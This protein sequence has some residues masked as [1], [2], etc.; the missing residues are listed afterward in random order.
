MN[1]SPVSSAGIGSAGE[2]TLASL[3]TRFFGKDEID[4]C[5]AI[6]G[7]GDFL[8]TIRRGGRVFRFMIEAKNVVAVPTIGVEK[9]VRD[10]GRPGI[11]GA[12]FVVLT[13][14][15]IPTKGEVAFEIVGSI[16]VLYINNVAAN[17]EALRLGVEALVFAALVRPASVSPGDDDD[18]IVD[19]SGIRVAVNTAFDVLTHHA[20]S[21]RALRDSAKSVLAALTAVEGETTA[22]VSAINTLWASRPDLRRAEPPPPI[23]V[24]MA[25]GD[26]IELAVVA[27]RQY[28]IEHGRY[29]SI[30]EASESCGVTSTILSKTHGIKNIILRARAL[31]L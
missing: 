16:P 1:P 20:T 5:S 27:V 22:A 19:D 7:H 15:N 13:P 24:V 28:F 10:C 6:S 2:T 11:D 9:F 23:A 31:I 26:P 25:A 8:L 3:L 29:P 14:A 4:K 21:F 12:L 30:K 18:D 17:P